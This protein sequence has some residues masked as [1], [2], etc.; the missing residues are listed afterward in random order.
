MDK[1][2]IV[3][4]EKVGLIFLALSGVLDNSIPDKSSQL[5]SLIMLDRILESIIDRSFEIK[6]NGKSI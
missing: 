6:T 4:F 1:N 5:F 3:I 2:T